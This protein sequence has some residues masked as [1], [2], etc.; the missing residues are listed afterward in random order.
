MTC[1]N[2]K[3]WMCCWKDAASKIKFEAVTALVININIGNSIYLVNTIK[4]NLRTYVTVT[5]HIKICDTSYHLYT[6]INQY[7]VDKIYLLGENF[8]TLS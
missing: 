4:K 8:H 1:V 2:M 6:P 3:L 7:Q 5:R